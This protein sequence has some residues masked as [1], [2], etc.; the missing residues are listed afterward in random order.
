[1]VVVVHC[2]SCCLVLGV[3]LEVDQHLTR[4][5]CSPSEC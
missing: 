2:L 1:L 4:T 3:S 5:W